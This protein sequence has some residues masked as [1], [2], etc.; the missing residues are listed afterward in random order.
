MVSGSISYLGGYFV[1]NG[2]Y[3]AKLTAWS[4]LKPSVFQWV[5]LTPGATYELSADIFTDGRAKATLGVKWENYAD[6]PTTGFVN[7]AFDHKVKVRF[8]VPSGTGKVGIYFTTSATSRLTTWATVD[9]FKL[10]KVG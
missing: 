3:A 6:G 9:N 5:S 4:T 10:V 8:T 7:T 2:S 1:T